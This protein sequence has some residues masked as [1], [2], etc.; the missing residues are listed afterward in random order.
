[1]H[2]RYSAASEAMRARNR[3]AFDALSELTGTS[4]DILSEPVLL[5]T[6][7]WREKIADRSKQRQLAEEFENYA[8]GPIAIGESEGLAMP[9][10]VRY[11]D[12]DIT[13]APVPR[14]T[15]MSMQF[16]RE[17][18]PASVKGDTEEFR[19]S[20][21]HAEFLGTIATGRY[22]HYYG[23]ASRIPTGDP[24]NYMMLRQP[25]GEY[26]AEFSLG[27]LRATYHTLRGAT[28]QQLD[29]L[30]AAGES[31]REL[32]ESHMTWGRKMKQRNDYGQ[33]V[34]LGFPLAQ[35]VYEGDISNAQAIGLLTAEKVPGF[36]TPVKLWRAAMEAK[37]VEQ[38][39]R[40]MTFGNLAPITTLNSFIPDLVIA[41]AKDQVD[42][43]PD[44]MRAL[45]TYKMEVVEQ[46]A[47]KYAQ[48]TAG[49]SGNEMGIFC[50][51]AVRHGGITARLN[52]LYRRYEALH[53]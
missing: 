24:G 25:I 4:S 28:P 5:G 3:P 11:I 23:A 36:S 26:G 19:L 27:V 47:K 44:V 6:G 33:N 13:R 48:S 51:A 43:N 18:L 45:R 7:T 16:Y 2:E 46:L 53:K 14:P 17:H 20:P 32:I 9:E 22:T 34:P 42:I 41:K 31:H 52:I 12:S 39:A 49:P 21:L 35:T 29:Q 8:F 1:M 30:S 10:A 15:D 50:P 37:L 38:L 40:T